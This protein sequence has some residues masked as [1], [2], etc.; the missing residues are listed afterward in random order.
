MKLKQDLRQILPNY[1]AFAASEILVLLLK[2]N[3]ESIRDAL[4]LKTNRA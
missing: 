3:G 4:Y 1:Q 2:L